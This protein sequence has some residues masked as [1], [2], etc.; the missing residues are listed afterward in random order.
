MRFLFVDRISA[1]G[2]DTVEGRRVFGAREPLQYSPW[3]GVAQVAPG[4]ASEAIGQLASWLCLARN[5]FMAR[6][7]FLFAEAIEVLGP[8]PVGSDVALK[9]SISSMDESTFVFSGE[10]SVDGVVVQ[11][12]KD[13]SGYF[14]PLE[15]LENP[16]VT[17][18]R[19]AALT[20]AEGLVLE[21]A[22]G[23]AFPFST[24]VDE[25]KFFDADTEIRAEKRFHTN[26]PFYA[27]HFPRFPVTP[28]VMLN[29]MIGATATRLLCNAD[30]R[31]AVRG[32]KDIK[33]K[34]FV[35]P[36]E[37]CETRVKVTT[38]ETGPGGVKCFRTIAEVLKDGKR[39]LRGLYDYELTE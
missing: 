3:R 28:I 17:R 12:I 5:D 34:S 16:A 4:A 36:G 33:I 29:E 7:V 39:I 18:E 25:I 9:A 27:D 24:L 19:F 20:S 23:A 2:G 22:E 32:I 1:L 31:L 13:C 35:K 6:P 30:Q 38:V 21:G 8:I 10:A 11:R 15:E 37:I 26:A 14:M